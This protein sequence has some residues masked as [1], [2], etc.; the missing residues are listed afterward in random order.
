MLADVCDCELFPAVDALPMTV[1]RAGQLYNH[2]LHI[3][4]ISKILCVYAH[5]L[6]QLS[7]L[8]YFL[9]RR[10]DLRRNPQLPLCSPYSHLLPRVVH[11]F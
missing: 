8:P 4:L 9:V 7:F 10:T 3:P 2:P 6:C 11:I 5:Q 1:V